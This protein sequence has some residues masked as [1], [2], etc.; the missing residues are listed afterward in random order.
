MSNS[1]N[2]TICALAT[3]PGGAIAV[4]RVSGNESLAIVDKVFHKA[5]GKPLAEVAPNTIHYGQL[6][7]SEGNAIDEV[8]HR[9]HPPCVDRVR[10][11][12]SGA[13][14]VYQTGLP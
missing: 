2:D 9:L 12:T 4:V 14:R 6:T 8:S 7:D 5:N 3:R 13:W 11:P 1:L 10:V